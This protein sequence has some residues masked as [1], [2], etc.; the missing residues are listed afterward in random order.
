MGKRERGG[1]KMNKI[2]RGKGAVLSVSLFLIVIFLFTHTQAFGAM[3]P[4]VTRLLTLSDQKF[5]GRV[6][7]DRTGSIYIADSSANVIRIY[8]HKGS[9][10]N[11]IRLPYTP[12]SGFRPT[13]LAVSPDNL[14]YVGIG[15]TQASDNG[16]IEVYTLEGASVRTINVVNPSAIA[17]L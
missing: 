11:L 5:P 8:S 15:K 2:M 14:L 3:A 7:S 12:Q 13:A 1:M 10:K 6:A 9:Y 17:F 16:Y 4:D